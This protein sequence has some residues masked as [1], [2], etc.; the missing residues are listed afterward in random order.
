[1]RETKMGE[2][3]DDFTHYYRATQR[4]TAEVAQLREQLATWQGHARARRDYRLVDTIMALEAELAVANAAVLR[5][6]DQAKQ[7]R[8]QLEAAGKRDEALVLLLRT[9]TGLT[10]ER[11][12]QFLD[13]LLTHHGAGIQ[14]PM[15]PFAQAKIDEA[16]AQ[17]RELRA[18]LEDARELAL[19]LQSQDYVFAEARADAVDWL[20][21]YDAL[22]N[23]QK[24]A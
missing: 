16:E 3:D 4:L 20:T 10:E 12:E 15:P 23:P 1:M 8:E 14:F 9:G 6:G 19:E 22:S 2:Q 21:R 24:G 18:L 13:D 17:L 7:L 11:V 5:E